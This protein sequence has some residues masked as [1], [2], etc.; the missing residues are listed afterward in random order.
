MVETNYK[1]KGIILKENSGLLYW[2][3]DYFVQSSKLNG[4]N[5]SKIVDLEDRKKRFVKK[6][7]RINEQ[8]EEKILGIHYIGNVLYYFSLKN[9]LTCISKKDSSKKY[10]TPKIFCWQYNEKM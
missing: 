6:K 7:N 9:G 1:I 2:F 5:I 8:N 4:E 3:G 10:S